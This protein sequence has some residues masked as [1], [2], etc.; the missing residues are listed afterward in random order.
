MSFRPPPHARL[1]K[2]S[3]CIRC[4]G[5]LCCSCFG[6]SCNCSLLYLDPKIIKKIQDN[7]HLGSSNT[8]RRKSPSPLLSVVRA[9]NAVWKIFANCLLLYRMMSWTWILSSHQNLPFF[10]N[11]TGKNKQKNQKFW[12]K[13]YSKQNYPNFFNLLLFFVTKS[14]A[15]FKDNVHFLAGK[16]K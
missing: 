5:R 6:Y 15:S 14:C 4:H 16:S 9:N 7:Q 12:Q 2:I 1:H 10:G 3:S 13:S 11:V 8:G